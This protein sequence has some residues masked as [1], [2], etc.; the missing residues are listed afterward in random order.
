MPT[1]RPIII[2]KKKVNHGGHHGG[3]WKVAIQ[4]LV[5][6]DEKFADD[7]VVAH[8]RTPSGRTIRTLTPHSSAYGHEC[9]LRRD[10]L[11]KRS[12]TAANVY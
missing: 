12:G 10:G 9:L 11:S 8:A 6:L 2:V 4:I 5:A 1:V 3:A 7:F